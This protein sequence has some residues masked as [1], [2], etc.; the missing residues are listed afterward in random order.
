MLN[1]MVREGCIEDTKRGAVLTQRGRQKLKESCISIIPFNSLAELPTK[2]TCTVHVKGKAACITDGCEQRDHAVRAGAEAAITLVAVKDKIVF[3]R[4]E[5][6]PDPM[7][8]ESLKEVNNIKNG[9]VVIIGGA[10]NYPDA[11]KGAVTAALSLS[12][13]TKSCWNE[14][15]SIFTSDNEEEDVKCIALTIHE[16]VGRLPVTMRTKNHYGVRCEEG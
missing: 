2:F 7:I 14:G 13:K 5:R 12:S 3:P 11:E 6:F 10:G 4:D 16:L 9:D 15:V 1:K 8:V